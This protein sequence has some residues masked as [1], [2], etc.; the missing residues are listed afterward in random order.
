VIQITD[1]VKRYSF[2]LGQT[3][4]FKHFVDIKVCRVYCTN[5][6]LLTSWSMPACTRPRI[7]CSYGCSTAAEEAW[8]EEGVGHSLLSY[9]VIPD[10]VVQRCRGWERP[11]TQV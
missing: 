5:G 6:T 10:A 7:R 1:S 3:E 11:S 4:L 8:P 9:S 2:L